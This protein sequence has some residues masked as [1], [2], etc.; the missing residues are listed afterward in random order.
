MVLVF[1]MNIKQEGNDDNI[2]KTIDNKNIG[3]DLQ[4][5]WEYH[6]CCIKALRAPWN[7]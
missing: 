7:L 3:Q 5:G 1:L 2:K 6:F 4:T